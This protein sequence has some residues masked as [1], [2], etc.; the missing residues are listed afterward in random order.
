MRVYLIILTSLL[1]NFCSTDR[2]NLDY[3]PDRTEI[4]NVYLDQPDKET[5]DKFAII[6][7]L[8]EEQIILL[9]RTLNAAREIGPVKFMP[10]YFIIFETKSGE[11]LKL[12]VNGNKIK[13]YDSDLTY[14]IAELEF[15]EK[16]G[17]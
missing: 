13:G 16:F 3:P 14:E 12:K 17:K 5:R 10:E 8:T 9:L 15:L 4:K 2:P 7:N 6:Q 1:F 11:T